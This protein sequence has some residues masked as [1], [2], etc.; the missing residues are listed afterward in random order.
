MTQHDFLWVVEAIYVGTH[1]PRLPAEVPPP[2]VVNFSSYNGLSEVQWNVPELS[3]SK[4]LCSN[5]PMLEALLC[6]LCFY[7][8]SV[9][10]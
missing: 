7:Y 5:I 2:P 8:I 3:G 9:K 6:F 4:T 1:K 10:M